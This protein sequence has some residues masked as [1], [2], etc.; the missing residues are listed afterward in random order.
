[1]PSAL[2]PLRKVQFG[3]EST[4][5]TLV[6][7][8]RQLVGDCTYSPDLQRTYPA[9]LR[10]LR[11]PQA[12]GGVVTRRGCSLTVQTAL[13]YEQVLLFLE[14]GF[15]TRVT[16][17]GGPYTHTFT[18][19]TANNPSPKTMT[20]EFVA[21]DGAAKPYERRFGHAVTR[22]L[23][24]DFAR[25]TEA[26]LTAQLVGRAEQALT[27]TGGLAPLT[28]TTVQSADL[29]FA[30]DPTWATLGTTDLP[31]VFIPPGELVFRR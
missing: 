1:M 4:S 6:A 17:G 19:P 13:D 20:C 30:V 16:T 21:D 28:R 2:Y 23:A 5:G 18:P 27:M 11:A 9:Y 3:L 29:Q 26:R 10:S 14:T 12:D 25:G 24:I 15:A 22:R 8:S 31:P 7:A